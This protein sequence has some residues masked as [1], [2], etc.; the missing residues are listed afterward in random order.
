MF[1]TQA[2][3][4][5]AT[6]PQAFPAHIGMH[7]LADFYGLSVAVACD[8]ELLSSCL[9]RAAKQCHLTPLSTPVVHV[10]A[11]GGLTAFLPLSESHIAL[12]TYP[13]H[14]YLALDI[15]SCGQG[16]PGLAV[17]VFRAALAPGRVDVKHMRRGD[18]FLPDAPAPPLPCG[19]LPAGPLP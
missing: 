19:P 13:E 3:G 14:G 1:E 10:F 12:H 15:F 8:A 17:E 18:Q 16:D 11:G 4:S 5:V 9:L 7:V 2:P 6:K